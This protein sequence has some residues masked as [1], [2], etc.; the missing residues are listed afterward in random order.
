VQLA[1]NGGGQVDVMLTHV[2]PQSTQGTLSVWFFDTGTSTYAGL[3][4]SDSSN[5]TYFFGSNVVDFA[6]GYGSPYYWHGPGVNETS[7]SVLRT[8]GWHQLTLEIAPTGFTAFVDGVS[9]GSVAGSFTFD[10]VRLLVSGP[11]VTGTSYF[12]DFSA[13]Y[14]DTTTAVP[15]PTSLVLVSAGLLGGAARRWRTRRF[16]APA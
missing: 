5:P 9:T 8:P 7:S 15:E 12:D 13:T 10:T 6:P 4:A 11:G 14:E 1:A 16:G 2:F 3:Y